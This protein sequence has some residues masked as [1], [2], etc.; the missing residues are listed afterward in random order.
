MQMVLSIRSNDVKL[1][2]IASSAMVMAEQRQ[3]IVHIL[4]HRN[5]DVS[6]LSFTE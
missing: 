6:W 4:E 1:F 5:Q 2:T 3:S